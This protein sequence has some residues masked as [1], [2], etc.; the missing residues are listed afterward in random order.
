MENHFSPWSAVKCTDV[1]LKR[2]VEE[3]F[4]N[5]PRNID[6]TISRFYIYGEPN[7]IETIKYLHNQFPGLDFQVVHVFGSTEAGGLVSE[8][9]E[10]DIDL[11]YIYYYD[12]EN[13]III[14]TYDHQVFH[15]MVKDEEQPLTPEDTSIVL[16]NHPIKVIPCGLI[17]DNIKINSYNIGEGI[18][19]KKASGDIF[20]FI[21]NKIYALG[22]KNE[23]IMNT[24]LSI[25]DNVISQEI[26]RKT[27][28][29]YH[30]DS[31]YLA[32]CYPTNKE[33]NDYTS[34]FRKLITEAKKT[35]HYIKSHYSKIKDVLFIP[36]YDFPI[37][38]ISNKSKRNAFADKIEKYQIINDRLINYQESF[39]DHVKDVL[40]NRLGFVPNFS[41]DENMNIII[42]YE[43]ISEKQLIEILNDLNIVCIEKDD[44]HRYY[45]I[46]YDD[47]YLF[48]I[49]KKDLYHEEDIEEYRKL[50][51]IGL[52]I[53]KL[54]SDNKKLG[55]VNNISYDSQHYHHI[56]VLAKM[57][58]DED[59]NTI[60][61]A[62]FQ[63]KL[64]APELTVINRLE[65]E[66]NINS[67]YPNITFKEIMFEAY[68]NTNI[69]ITDY[70]NHPIIIQKDGTVIGDSRDKIMVSALQN[71]DII[72]NSKV[73]HEFMKIK[74]ERS[75]KR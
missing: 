18:I 26:N 58:I 6:A 55:L 7:S 22:R 50:A 44:F 19:D 57:G 31:I 46:V 14:Y 25:I 39:K 9:E 27:T 24:S 40:L 30:N 12:L 32:V 29:F 2:N 70:F 15:K 71:Q 66:R 1:Y 68:I 62:F 56:M 23:L 33:Y 10:K 41:I 35:R 69:N 3:L 42:P 48:E 74:R 17:N 21:N 5:I 61:F 59:G 43:Q 60:L 4:K 72:K 13:D 20:A 65:T 49:E 16:E 52:F 37:N 45:H 28:A 8:C 75:G 64:L 36:E 53:P 73:E 34:Y 51:D 67:R 63:S 11:I 47:S 54:L 38:K